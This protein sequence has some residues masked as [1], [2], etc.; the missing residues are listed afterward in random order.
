M[1][2]ELPLNVQI[3][4]I[5]YLAT[6]NFPQAKRLHDEWLQEHTTHCPIIHAKAA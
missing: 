1:L 2:A 5:Q 3:R 4:V 6:D